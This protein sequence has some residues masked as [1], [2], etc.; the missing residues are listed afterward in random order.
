M[1]VSKSELF[2]DLA[3]EL[4]S[5]GHGVRFRAGGDSMHPAIR[6]GEAVTVEPVSPAA[7]RRGDVVLYQSARGLTV[8]R[9][10]DIEESQFLM[11]GDSA[12]SADEPVER[13]RILGK[14]VAVERHFLTRGVLLAGLKTLRSLCRPA[15]NPTRQN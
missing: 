3:A 2:L 1:M 15:P 8:H 13:Q 9:L 14:V 4:L 11:R 12:G 7:L 10:V 5:R 6:D